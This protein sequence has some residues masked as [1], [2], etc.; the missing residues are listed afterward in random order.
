[1]GLALTELDGL[2]KVVVG[3]VLDDLADLDGG[4]E[5]LG[6]IV[7]VDV[8]LVV[9]VAENLSHFECLLGS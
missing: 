1:M 9:G 2:L 7:H 3:E 6:E 4:D 5:V 8:L